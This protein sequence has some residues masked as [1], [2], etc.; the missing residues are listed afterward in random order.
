MEM[1]KIK[2]SDI[3]KANQ[4]YSS[5]RSIRPLTREDLKN[6]VRVFLGVN[7]PDTAVCAG[8]CSP[9]DYLWHCY[10]SDFVDGVNVSADAV[11]WANR[12]GGKTQLAAIATLL[13]SI[14]KPGCSVRI[15]GGSKEQSSRM[16]EYFAQFVRM[17]FEGFIDGQV[18][19]ER[20]SFKN[21]STVQMLAQSSRN[22]R[23]QHVNKL[24]CD[25][26][27]LFD[28]DV[29]NA[30]KF[31][32]QS[33]NGIL[34][35]MEL[36]STMHRPYGLMHEAVVQAG[37]NGTEIFKWCLWE[38]VEKCVDRN[39]S[40]CK[41][42][43]DCKGVS[44]NAD[45]YFKIDDCLTQMG[46]SSRAGFE[47]E[48]LCKKPSMENM[49]FSQ[50]DTSV[51]VCRL[52]YNPSLPL[53]RAIDF[54]FVNPFVCL[55]IQVDA[56][57]VVRVI[58]EYFR[59]RSPIRTNGKQMVKRTPCSEEGVAANFCDPAGAGVND[60]TGTSSVRELKSMG[61]RTR[62]RRSRILEG[63][64]LIRRGLQSGD[65]Q[66]KLLVSSRCHKLIEAMQCYHYPDSSA[67]ALSELPQKDGIY[68]HPID[69]LRY[70]YV[71][72]TSGAKA[73]SRRY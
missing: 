11:V 23:G 1:N 32:T 26:I 73:T 55:W 51:H 4:L 10:N 44:K 50:F 7:I 15:L 49:V 57:G 24:R 41:L 47:S 63:I 3:Q 48:M 29:F 69:A 34:A 40:Q 2:Q 65:G 53:Y 37:D 61:I 20:C 39:C 18:L 31:V 9:M 13:D 35:G 19:K 60:V 38:V 54:G 52:D 58:D 21:G 45:G 43:S 17:G 25:E 5:L 68:D 42:W 33:T 64:E 8:H 66:V 6:Y 46:R 71:N 59:S 62:Y 27:E 16:Y 72:Y 22:I 67:G 70:F 28:E 14:F 56:G 12:G 36:V 30:A